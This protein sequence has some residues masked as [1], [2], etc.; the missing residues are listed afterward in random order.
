MFA[1]IYCWGNPDKWVDRD[2]VFFYAAR[3]NEY[4][5]W[6]QFDGKPETRDWEYTFEKF[7]TVQISAIWLKGDVCRQDNYQRNIRYL[8]DQNEALTGTMIARYKFAN[9]VPYDIGNESFYN[10][11]L[12]A[13]AKMTSYY[14]MSYV[15][16]GTYTDYKGVGL[17]FVWDYDNMVQVQMWAPKPSVL[18]I[19]NDEINKQFVQTVEVMRTEMTAITPGSDEAQS[20]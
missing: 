10:P 1:E 12:M 17:D 3:I 2:Q 8:H 9:Q 4:M 18:L 6:R 5:N 11:L 13:T 7:A 19:Y 20:L 15:N 16:T 14:L